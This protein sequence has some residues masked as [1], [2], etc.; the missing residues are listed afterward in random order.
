VSFVP[1]RIVNRRAKVKD[2]LSQFQKHLTEAGLGQVSEIFDGNAPL[3]ARGYIAQA[4]SVAESLRGAIA[5]ADLDQTPLTKGARAV[6]GR[7]HG[8]SRVGAP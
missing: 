8:R 2:C 4:W 7:K 5:V 1:V 6:S 3:E